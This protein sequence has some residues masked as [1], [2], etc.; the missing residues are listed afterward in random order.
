MVLKTIILTIFFFIFSQQPAAFLRAHTDDH[1]NPDAKIKIAHGT[2][3]LAFRF[4]GGIVSSHPEQNKTQFTFIS[5][6]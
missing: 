4:Q 6:Q 5:R 1:A 2:T 3:T